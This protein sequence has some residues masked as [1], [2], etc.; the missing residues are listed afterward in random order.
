[1]LATQDEALADTALLAR[2]DGEPAHWCTAE[3]LRIRALRLQHAGHGAQAEALLRQAL[4][5]AAQQGAVAWQ[6]RCASSLAQLLHGGPQAA[7]GRDGL[8]ALLASLP[9]GQDTPDRRRAAAI[10]ATTA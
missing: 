1:M 6:L 3:L 10:L 7:A 8:A 5:L 9:Q 4:A 2:L